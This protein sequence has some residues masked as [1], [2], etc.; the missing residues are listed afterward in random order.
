LVFAVIRD[1]SLPGLHPTPAWGTASTLHLAVL[2]LSQLD[3]D[4]FYIPD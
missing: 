4:F 3:A 1:P 2:D